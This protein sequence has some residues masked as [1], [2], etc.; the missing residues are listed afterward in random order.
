MRRILFFATLLGLCLLAAAALVS[1]AQTQT[2]GLDLG[3]PLNRPRIYGLN[4]DL[5]NANDQA[6]QLEAAQQ[7]GFAWIRQS[8]NYQTNDWAA[9]D[10][11]IISANQRRLRLAAVLT[12]SPPPDPEAFTRFAAD[13]ASRYADQ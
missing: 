6:K 4:V 2:R 3:A 12:G 1:Q 7:N 10:R 8:F 9:S 11:L 5:L 13:F